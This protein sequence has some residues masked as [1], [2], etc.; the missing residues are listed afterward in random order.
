[1]K[2]TDDVKH[3]WR[4]LSIALGSILILDA[5]VVGF[6]ISINSGIIA[7]FVLGVLYLLAGLFHDRVFAKARKRTLMWVRVI[8]LVVNVLLLALFAFIAV[9]GRVDTVSH[10]ED[11]LIVLGTGLNGEDITEALAMQRY[12]VG[13][14]VPEE[15]ILQEGESTSTVENFEF[16]R[17]LLEEHFDGDYTTAFITSDYHVFRS[18]LSTAD[19]GMSSTHA[20]ANTPWYQIAVDY[21]REF[22][23]SAKFVLTR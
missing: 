1:M 5:L 10:E 8:V 18:S 7:T 16:T 4:I 13:H 11:A 9:F 14:G 23:A 3:F 17:E 6:M 21:V 22:L 19:A 2:G 20:Y 15:L 12:L